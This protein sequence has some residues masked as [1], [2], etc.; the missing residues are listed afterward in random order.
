MIAKRER[1]KLERRLVASLT[2]ACEQAKPRLP[3]FCWLTHEVDDQR[4]PESLVV[5]WVFDTHAHLAQALKGDARRHIDELTAAAAV[6]RRL[7]GVHRSGLKH[8][9]ELVL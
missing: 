1:G 6:L 2:H 5:T 4:F 7:L 3:G 8:G 9:V